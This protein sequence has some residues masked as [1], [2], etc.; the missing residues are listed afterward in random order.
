MKL[1]RTIR[2]DASDAF[3]FPSPAEDGEWA[4]SGA[5]LFTEMSPAT[6]KGQDLAAFRSGFLGVP[7][8]GWSTLA[9]IVEAS[10]EDRA[11]AID[12]LAHCFTEQLGAPD[13][14]TA[15]RAATEEVDFAISLC[16]HPAGTLVAVDRRHEDGAV[17]EAFRTLR[18]RDDFQRWPVI[19]LEAG[20][21]EEEQTT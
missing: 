14:R 4:I 1:L 13:Q 19:S 17:H 8:L 9:Q 10:A 5:F 3:L 15:L 21:K 7:S 18:Q 12:L 11:I 16:D 6:L 2:L 20:T